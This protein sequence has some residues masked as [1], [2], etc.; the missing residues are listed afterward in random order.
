M[1]SD[2]EL[3]A[4]TMLAECQR[5][6]EF[7]ANRCAYLCADIAVTANE[8]EALKKR[9]TELETQIAGN[10]GSNQ[11]TSQTRMTT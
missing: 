1:T 5:Q 4:N 6:R 10:A 11:R 7:Y 2:L 9:I 8:I 3:R